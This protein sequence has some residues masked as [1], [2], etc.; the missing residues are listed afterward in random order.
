MKSVEVPHFAFEGPQPHS[1]GLTHDA[2]RVERA[3][4]T[5]PFSD[6]TIVVISLLYFAS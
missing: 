2:V 5:T 6:L 3:A 1:I 4:G